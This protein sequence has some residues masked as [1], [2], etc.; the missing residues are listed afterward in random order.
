MSNLFHISGTSKSIIWFTVKGQLSP[1][2]V[3]LCI[4]VNMNGMHP[5]FTSTW[6]QYPLHSVAVQ[7]LVMTNN[8]AHLLARGSSYS[9]FTTKLKLAMVCHW[10]SR[11]CVPCCMTFGKLDFS[12]FVSSVQVIHTMLAVCT[13]SENGFRFCKDTGLVIPIAQLLNTCSATSITTTI[14]YIIHISQCHYKTFGFHKVQ[15]IRLH[16]LTK[17]QWRL[18][19]WYRSFMF[20]LLGFWNIFSDI[21]VFTSVQS[22]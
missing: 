2:Q 12:W 15:T 14:Y 21:F 5:E 11:E 20:H 8:E 1:T 17:P 4:N 9:L 3:S 13:L 7:T 16:F 19:T 18:D 10:L 6:E 22:R